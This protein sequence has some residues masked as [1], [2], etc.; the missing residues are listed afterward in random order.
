M[1]LNRLRLRELAVGALM[2][3]L[4]KIIIPAEVLNK[5]GPL[6][7]AEFEQV[8]QHSYQGFEIL[9]QQGE[10]GLLSAHVALQHHERIDG[11]GYPRGL[12]GTDIHEYG[13]I[14]AVADVYDALVSD[15]A[16][17]P[18]YLPHQAAEILVEESHTT[19]DDQVVRCFLRKVAFY[20]VGTVVR[21]STGVIGVVVDVNQPMTV[22]P[23][24]RILYDAEGNSL[25][26]LYEVDLTKDSHIS[27]IEVVSDEARLA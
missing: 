7:A 23:V 6:T 26:E 10:I 1:R 4:G 17:R 25:S 24:V 2:H 21:L 12:A 18:R 16:Y 13:R 27:I 3:D 11:T 8:K 9:R 15:R 20:P 5:P 14:V 22:R 19:L